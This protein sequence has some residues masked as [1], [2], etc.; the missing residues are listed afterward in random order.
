M[1]KLRLPG[2]ISITQV[3]L[4][5]QERREISTHPLNSKKPG[6]VEKEPQTEIRQT[7][8]CRHRSNRSTASATGPDFQTKLSQRERFRE[9][10][11]LAASRC[12][13]KKKESTQHLKTR[14]RDEAQKKRQLEGEIAALRGEILDLKDEVLKYALCEDGH[15]GR[16]L[17]QTMQRITQGTTA[18][19]FSSPVSAYSSTLSPVSASLVTATPS[20]ATSSAATA[21]NI[22]DK[23]SLGAYG[24]EGIPGGIGG[25]TLPFGLEESHL[26]VDRTATELI[27]EYTYLT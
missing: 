26:L 21:A 10:N 13:Q 7:Y 18:G 25:K 22:W 27:D 3:I 11:R 1:S 17:A 6:K 5:Q 4:H 16:N 2:G 9:K 12:R 8:H 19:A 14:F 15:V 23:S 24:E 20:K